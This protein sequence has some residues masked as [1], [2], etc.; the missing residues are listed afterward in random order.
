MTGTLYIVG[1][2][3]GDPELL[4]PFARRILQQVRVVIGYDG[5]LKLLR[6]LLDD[7]RQR[8]EGRALSQETERAALAVQYS[9][10]GRDVAVVSSGDA[11]V[12]GMAG[13][14]FEWLRENPWSIVPP[15]EVIPGISAIQAAAARVGAPIMHDF[16]VISLSD[17]LT[18]WPNIIRRL[19]HAAQGDFVLGLYNP[20]S[21][22]RQHQIEKARDIF[23]RYRDPGTPVAVVRNAYRTEESVIMSDLAH[24]LDHRVD[25]FSIVIVGNSQSMNWKGRFVKPRGYY[26]DARGPLGRILILGGT[27]EGRLMAQRLA[28]R[29]FPV[30][31]SYRK[32]GVD[33]FGES[34]ETHWGD[35]DVQSLKDFVTRYHVSDIV[36]MTHPD[37]RQM[38]QTARGV[39]KD[40]GLRYVRYQRPQIVPRSALI[41]VVSTHEEAAVLASAA[42][43]P[44]MLMIGTKFLSVYAL[45]LLN[46]EGVIPVIRILPTSESLRQAEALGFS[47]R[48][49]VAMLGPYSRDLNG[50]LYD[51]YS[52]RLVIV[53][54]G[55]YDLLEKI[56][57][58]LERK[59][60]VVIVDRSASGNGDNNASDA[61]TV[62]SLDDLEKRL[63]DSR[64]R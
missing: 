9:R 35:W 34:I 31:L 44:V 21:A 7:K 48:H 14:V 43:G 64:P 23:L 5:Y 62:Y 29:Q 41:T 24:F 55:S 36:D 39:S 19:H 58:A 12:Y 13:V 37:S 27:I 40:M 30:T 20:R 26:P 18:P 52:P 32:F 3:P 25:M 33:T 49:I 51:R 6:P 56:E 2:G 38:Q 42:S 60:P 22:K 50:A 61:D 10:Q 47:S 8:I 16:A 46:T 28:A 15:I 53:K 4:T 17:L 54:V 57:P 1:I 63:C 59:I 11:G 45:R